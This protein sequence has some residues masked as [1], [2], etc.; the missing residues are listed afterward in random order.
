MVVEETNRYAVQR[1]SNIASG[2]RRHQQAWKPVTKREMSTFIVILLIMGVVRLPEIRLY[3]SKKEMYG[4]ARIKKAMKRDRFMSILK[5][6]HFTDNTTDRIEDRLYKVR[7]IVDKIVRTSRNTVKPGKNIVIDES[8]VP[9]R[10]R[11]SFRQY[12]PGKRHKYGI[13]MY[14]L[15]LPGGYTYNIHIYSGMDEA[16]CGKPHSQDVVMKL[17][18]N[19][20]FVRR[21]LFTDSFYTSVPLAEELLGKD[22][23]ICGTIRMNNKFLPPQAKQK[24]KRGDIM[25][26]QNRRGVKFMKWTDKRPVCMLTTSSNHKCILI[27]GKKDKVKPD[28]VF[29]YNDAKK[30]VDL[31]DQ[32]SSYYNSL[33]RTIKWYRKL[34]IQLICGTCLVNTWYVHIKWGSKRMKIF[35]FRGKIID[36]LLMD[37]VN[38]PREIITK[39]KNYF[40][41]SYEG[42]ARKSRRRCKECYKRLANLRGNQY[43]MKTTKKVKT[44]CNNCEGKPALCLTCFKKLHKK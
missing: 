13:K 34:V 38:S 27:R 3:W 36:H 5:Y 23:Y 33:R 12:I 8:M 30:G 15:C 10:G 16:R 42:P 24:Q 25:S 2:S 9:W 35:K 21:I 1:I 26:F 29:F 6:L 44:F 28:T 41:S 37:V 17:I 31:S 20:L 7:D 19:L 32:M 43:V 40:L 39:N 11:L 4:N 18:G 14:K 22:T